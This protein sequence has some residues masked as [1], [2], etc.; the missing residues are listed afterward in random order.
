MKK[1]VS[2]LSRAQL[3]YQIARDRHNFELNYLEFLRYHL[4]KQIIFLVKDVKIVI[5]LV[6]FSINLTSKKLSMMLMLVVLLI[7]YLISN[8]LLEIYRI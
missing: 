4:I 1:S 3:F 5:L 2:A 6:L 8:H 7:I